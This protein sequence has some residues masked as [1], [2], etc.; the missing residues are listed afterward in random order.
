MT[1]RC[2]LIAVVAAALAGPAAAH[3]EPKHAESYEPAAASQVV[4]ELPPRLLVPPPLPAPLPSLGGPDASAVLMPSLGWALLRMAGAL[5][6]VGVLLAA[7]ALAYRRFAGQRRPAP[8][9][10]SRGGLR[11]FSQWMP[12]AASDADRV[13]I[14]SR[15]FLGSKESICVVQAGHE[16]FLVA[17]TGSGIS[18]LG[19]LQTPASSAEDADRP[20]PDSTPVDFA[21]ALSAAVRPRGA[22][23][24]AAEPEP[25]VPGLPSLDLA[26]DGPVP[27]AENEVDAIH[28]ALARSRI[29][30]D[31]LSRSLGGRG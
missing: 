6:V 8:A 4:A 20:T 26:D 28:A 11:W 30:L 14:V 5:V 1:R 16:R 21:S 7:S 13:Q 15:S 19:R 22:A 12:S 10:S 27:L 23:P 9:S 2:V 31:R 3:A 17:T 25:P 18:L 29:R 24:R